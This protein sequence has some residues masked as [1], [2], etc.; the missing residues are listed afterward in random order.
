LFQRFGPLVEPNF[1]RLWIGQTASAVGDAL[2]GVALTFAVLHLSGSAA[3]LGFVLA[4]FMVPRVVFMLIGGVWAD[5][6][7]RRLIMVTSDLVRAGAQLALAAAVFSGVTELWVF[8]LASAVS[9]AASAFFQPAV[10]GL[11]PQAISAPRLQQGN[12]LLN[13]SQSTAFMFGPIVSGVLVAAIGSGWIFAIDALSFLVSAAFLFMLAIPATPVE[14]HSFLTDLADGWKEVV[15]RRWLVGSLAAFAFANLAFACFFVLGPLVVERELNGAAD[16]GILMGTFGF[17]GLIGGVLGLRWRPAHPLVATFAVLLAGPA[18][19][20]ILSVAPP[21]PILAVGVA[22][23]AIATT[24]ANT[25]WHTTLQQQVPPES[26]SRVSSYDWM[27][28]LLIFP[29]GA[30][31]AGPLA[32][33]LG[34]DTALYLFAALS[35]IPVILVLGMRSVRAVRRT[36]E[37][38]AGVAG[39]EG[40][41]VAEPD[42]TPE[43]ISA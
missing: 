39:S 21:L 32:D 2:T 20:L 40:A 23:I 38:D 10:I 11:I 22:S 15:G 27:V 42:A 35:A 30:A 37:A 19:L 18:G 14:R 28:S 17:G 29:A 13:L 43:A 1:R 16:W 4:S 24:I 33:G 41:D 7:P 34:A 26:I 31:L 12:A 6:L 8:M 25:L 5:R 9:G 3:D 36:D